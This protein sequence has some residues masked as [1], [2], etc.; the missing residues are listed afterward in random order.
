MS[1]SPEKCP[2]QPEKCPILC[3]HRN[4]ET[5]TK[6]PRAEKFVASAYTTPKISP[7]ENPKTFWKN[8]HKNKSRLRL[9]AHKENSKRYI[10]GLSVDC[11]VAALERLKTRQH[12]NHVP[13]GCRPS[14]ASDHSALSSLRSLRL[15]APDQTQIAPVPLPDVP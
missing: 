10:E 4:R 8:N 1:D 5:K 3:K 6:K 9:T 15:A 2:S 12:G 11:H 13:Q 14:A 7:P